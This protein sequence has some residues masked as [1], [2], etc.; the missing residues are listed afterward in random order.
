M[1]E[2]LSPGVYIQ[3]VERGPRPIEGVGTATAAF[4][5]F[6]ASGPANSSVL[7]TNWSQYVNTFGSLEEGG[8]HNPHIPGAYLSHAV[9]GFFLNGGGRCYVTRVVASSAEEQLAPLQ[10]PNRASKAVP[11]L[12]ITP[13]STPSQDI[14]VNIVPPS[15]AVPPTTGKDE[16]SVEQPSSELFTLRVRMGDMEE[17]YENLSMGKQ[18]VKNA[19]E[20]VNQASQLITLLEAKSSGTLAERAPQLGSYIIKAPTVTTLPQVQSS[21]FQG[22]VA[23]RS[24]LEGLEVAEDVTMVCCPD[25]MAAYQAGAIDR[26]GVKAVQLAMIA[27]CER[28]GDRVAILDPLPDLSPQEV[29]RWREQETNYDSK[30]AVLY[31]PWIKIAGN[32][33]PLAIP[34]SGHMAGIYARSD[35]ERGVHKAPANE[36]A[37][38]A[39]EAVTQ[40]TKGEQDTLNPI[41]VNCIRSFTGRGLRVWGARTLSS[42]PAWRY[43][44]VRRLFNYIEKSIERGTQWVVFE[45]NDPDL[46]ARVK[47]DVGAFLTGSWR[48]GMLFGRVPEEAFFVKCDQENNPPDVRD[49]GQLF[50]DIGLAPVKPAEF[51]IFRLSQW[52]GGGA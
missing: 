42:D 23:E 32:G 51:V 2:Y 26:Q 30:F 29:K 12:T 8:A 13:R 7:I 44:N 33:Q 14:Q 1:P 17:V 47:R 21:N 11:S 52:A 5:G 35:N 43:I 48:D 9:Y 24:G 38:G 25:L 16:K 37:L 34:P 28:M 27:H 10:L 50:I 4:V 40:I 36:V 15:T 39:L 49:R 46:W 6:A 31:Y 19:V 41:G 3:E 45:P 18:G 20:T 22:S